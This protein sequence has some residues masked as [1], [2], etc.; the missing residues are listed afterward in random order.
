MQNVLTLDQMAINIG[1]KSKSQVLEKIACMAWESELINSKEAFLLGLKEREDEFSCGIGNGFAIPH[2][3]KSCVK[4]PA[5][6]VLKLKDGIDWDAIDGELVTCVIALAVPSDEAGTTH[7]KLLSKVA[8]LLMHEEFTEA[9]KK[10][11]TKEAL[12]EVMNTELE[13]D[14]S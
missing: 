1:A 4:K 3:K 14:L 2:C 10:A 7:L 6:L 5:V 8:K 11:Q 12:F 9:V 13:G